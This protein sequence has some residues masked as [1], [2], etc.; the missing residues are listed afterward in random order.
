MGAQAMGILESVD[1]ETISE[2]QEKL[3]QVIPEEL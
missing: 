2:L 1:A 3:V